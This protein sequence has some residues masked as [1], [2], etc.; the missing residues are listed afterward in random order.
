M[1]GCDGFMIEVHD[2]PQNALSDGEQSILP[3]EFKE[4]IEKAN[5]VKKVYSVLN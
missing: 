2:F 4:I 3:T 5:I 1:A